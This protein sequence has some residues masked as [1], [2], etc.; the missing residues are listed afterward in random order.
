MN[1]VDICVSRDAGLYASCIADNLYVECSDC[2]RLDKCHI[3]RTPSCQFNG[4]RDRRL[5]FMDENL[6]NGWKLAALLQSIVHRVI[7][8]N[9]LK[10]QLGV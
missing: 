1:I 3:L 6:K 4:Q 9:G 7:C 2:M 10:W 5:D 8:A